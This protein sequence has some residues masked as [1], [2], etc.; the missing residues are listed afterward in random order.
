MLIVLN[1][2]IVVLLLAS[3]AIW[4]TYGLFSALLH[5]L[6]VI[7]SGVIA[8]S[9]WEP[10]SYWLLGRMPEYAHGI[11]LLAP[12]VLCLII[13][14]AA[15]DQLCRMNVHVPRLADQI[16]GGAVGLI[17]GVLAFGMVFNAINFLPI[18]RDAFGWE[19]YSIRGSGMIPSE[20]GRLW[21]FTRINEW[22]GAFFST[23]AGGS[24]RPIGGTPLTEARPNLAQRAAIYRLPED[25]NQMR[26][27]HPD[28]V[29]VTGMYSVPATESE[30][31]KLVQ[32]AVVFQFLDETYEIPESIEFGADGSG[33]VDAILADLASR[34]EDSD[35]NGQPSDLLDIEHIMAVARTPG[36]ETENPTA[37][38]N[39]EPFV[40]SVAQ[41]L[42]DELIEQFK[43]QLGE[44]RKLVLIDTRWNN[45]S[46]GVYESDSRLRVA[47]SQVSLQVAS[48]EA[49]EMVN[50]AG[51]SVEYSQNSGGRTLTQT[52]SDTVFAAHSP[53]ADFSLGWLFSIQADQTPK[54]LFVREL[55]FEL[56]DLPD[57]G[58]GGE[59]GMSN[60]GAF[61][62]AMGAPFVQVIDDE[63]GEGRIRITVSDGGVLI[64][65]TGARA[66]VTERLPFPLSNAQGGLNPYRESEPWK[67]ISGA[68]EK[69]PQGKGGRD[70]TMREIFVQPN[71]RLVRVRMETREAQSL[72]GR[73]RDAG[74][75]LGGIEVRD[76][77][78]NSYPA[79]GYALLQGGDSLTFD[80]RELSATRPLIAKDLPTMR[81]GDQLYVYFSV[82]DGATINALR[83]ADETTRFNEP[84][85]IEAR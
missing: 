3:L 24:M 14:R 69:A 55:R 5:L 33:L 4:S 70:S 15:I 74:A 40:N 46:K 81:P 58:D 59:A 22:S 37:S 29:K 57:A 18:A 85:E 47:L 8:L 48:G 32:R 49:F 25:G 44:N 67:L 6:I 35:A 30:L 2:V 23:I 60:P 56:D 1:I 65:D 84:L 7:V 28:S 13:F 77:R 50:P 71:E 54:R 31:R 39:F 83:V 62:H 82:N 21:G 26:A 20:D 38:G 9:L 45:R 63:D 64:G 34:Y 75:S 73:F 12:F 11:G 78:G 43:P 10:L 80:I 17:S 68:R 52:V 72:Y 41:K 16:G 42:G 53:F 19:P 27:A 51:F 79:I 66:V 36:Y 76:S 61:A